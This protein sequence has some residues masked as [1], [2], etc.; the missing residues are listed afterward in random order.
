M[1]L[2]TVLFLSLSAASSVFS[3]VKTPVKSER[4][5]N[6][7]PEQQYK[8]AK[9]YALRL[10]NNSP[11]G[12]DRGNWLN[13][14]RNFRKIHLA[15]RKGTL[16]PT[17]LYMTA[18]MY[19]RMF[20]QFMVPLDLETALANFLELADLYPGHTLAD[21]ALFDAAECALLSKGKEQLADDLYHKIVI[22]YPQGDQY[23]KAKTR[24]KNPEK[25]KPRPPVTANLPANLPATLPA[26]PPKD[27]T[28]LSP[29]KYWSSENYTRIV[30][31]SAAPVSFT[32]SPVE[33]SDKQPR[34]LY[35]DFARSYAP[36]K[37]HP[38]GPVRDGLLKQVHSEQTSE[39][40][41][42]VILD[43]ESLFE[44]KIFS[45]TDPFRVIVDIHGT[46]TTPGSSP[47]PETRPT[48]VP[49]PLPV[50]EQD[51]AIA[52]SS[53]K[54]VQQAVIS[55]TDQKKRS[56][57]PEPALPTKA[58][59]R[60][61][62]SL[63][64]QL[65]LGV[66]KIVIDPGH[67][68]KDPGAMAFGLKEKEIVLKI[69]KK[70][71]KVLRNTY[72]YEV[73]LTRTKDIFIPL[74]E[75]TAIANTHKSDLFISI[76]INAHSDQA[77]GGIETYFLNLATDANAMRVAALENA[78]STHSIGELQDILAT[79][80]KNSKIDESS[81]LARFVQTNLVSSFGRNYKPRDLGVKQAPFYVLIGAEMPA[82]LAELS[83]ITNPE[84]AKLLQ[85]EQYLDRIAEQLAAGI[86]AYIDHHHTAAVKL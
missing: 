13:G 85:N 37:F 6:L 64:Q 86:V 62:L 4:V 48:I 19:R 9:E 34:Q 77:S 83:F 80:M 24:I 67:G 76:H 52:Q 70:L 60:E 29:I 73:V 53:K 45:L 39:D 54:D 3:A 26:T 15:E 72:R 84:E 7:S 81:R 69:S 41:V 1:F 40:T 66:R 82:I 14:A 61:K 12:K 21:D 31:Q 30:I 36:P 35:V 65:G 43:L 33:K 56:P 44:Y 58:T 27:L 5:E 68:G 55:L 17:S 79:L 49:Q 42:R 47:L 23:E 75:R 51:V 10:E 32:A 20:T 38:P 25:D 22:I 8:A 2:I 74:E 18:K 11:L 28:L 46:M 50:P 78:T 71:A 59:N 16:G 63:A 57:M